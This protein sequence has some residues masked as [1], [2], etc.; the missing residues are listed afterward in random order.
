[1]DYEEVKSKTS[2]DKSPLNDWTNTAVHPQPQF[3]SQSVLDILINPP[4][5]K[6]PLSG[7]QRL[8]LHSWMLRVKTA[9][10]R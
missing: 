8:I 9:K 7:N 4:N 2:S 1:M 10:D 3:R 6:H 5:I